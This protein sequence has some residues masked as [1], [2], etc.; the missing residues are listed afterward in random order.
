MIVFYQNDFKRRQ[1]IILRS[2]KIPPTSAK[3]CFYKKSLH[4]KKS[5]CIWI[6]AIFYDKLSFQATLKTLCQPSFLRDVNWFWLIAACEQKVGQ[7]LKKEGRYSFLT[8]WC[9]D[10]K[11]NSIIFFTNGDHLCWNPNWQCLN[12]RLIQSL[13]WSMHL[14]PCKL[15]H[16]LQPWIRE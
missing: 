10:S 8:L 6:K 16:N 5:L 15:Q 7:C 3:G 9:Y 11:G 2:K 13:F 1:I 12:L 14:S 4:S